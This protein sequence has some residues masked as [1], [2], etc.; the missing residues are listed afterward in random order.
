MVRAWMSPALVMADPALGLDPRD[1]PALARRVLGGHQ[2]EIRHE[3]GGGREAC[4]IANRRRQ[5]SGNDHIHATQGAQVVH[6]WQQRPVGDLRTQISIDAINPLFGQAHRFNAFLQ[7]DL[8]RWL[9]EA[10]IGQ[11]RCAFVQA[12]RPLG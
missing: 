9:G 4:R 8:L 11:P 5:A 7:H 10:L 3:S 12:R 1:A 6:Q 2:A